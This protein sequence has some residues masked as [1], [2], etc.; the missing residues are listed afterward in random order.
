[1]VHIP[2]DSFI[3]VF[4]PIKKFLIPQLSEL[5][6][7]SIEAKFIKEELA[8][9]ARKNPEVKEKALNQVTRR[10]QRIASIIQGR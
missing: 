2:C 6:T 3:C 7:F 4:E 5:K 1:M 10:S 9:A 8:K